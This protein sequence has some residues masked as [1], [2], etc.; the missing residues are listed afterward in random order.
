MYVRHVSP[1]KRWRHQSGGQFLSLDHL[2]LDRKRHLRRLSKELTTASNSLLATTMILYKPLC[3]VR[4][5]EAEEKAII[6]LL[7][8]DAS[9]DLVLQFNESGLRNQTI[10]SLL[11]HQRNRLASYDPIFGRLKL[12]AMSPNPLH[13]VIVSYVTHFIMNA[14]QSQFFAETDMGKVS[15]SSDLMLMRT[16]Y[17]TPMGRKPLAFTKY[18][19]SIIVYGLPTERQLS[20]VV[21]EVALSESHEDLELNAWQWLQCS[22]GGGGWYALSFAIDVKEDRGASN[23]RRKTEGARSRRRELVQ[24]FGNGQARVHNDMFHDYDG[25]DFA[26]P[27]S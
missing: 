16:T 19:D 5:E 27:S 25:D 7:R 3:P 26:I 24:L 11:N 2:L 18:A 15:T 22:G 10:R 12:Y 20:T 6:Y 8:Q 23:T 4:Q 13:Q 21:F 17:D 9:R 14:H 1:S